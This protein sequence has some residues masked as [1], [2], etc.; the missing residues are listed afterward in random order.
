VT[1]RTL[2]HSFSAG[3]YDRRREATLSLAES[4]GATAVLAF[5]ENRSGIAV[6]Y[7][8]GWPVTRLAQYRLSR[9]ESSL[10]VTFHNHVP[11]ARRVA[12]GA[13]V[14]DADECT[15]DALVAG[16]SSLA[17]LGTVP[18][19]VRARADVAGTRLVPIDA[20]H[21][22]LRMVKSVE[23]QLALRLGAEASD[24]GA[25]ALIDACTPGATDWDLLAS[26]RDAYTR[27]GARDHICYISVTNMSSPDRD[28]PGQVLEGRVLRVGSVVTF[29]LSAA[30]AAEYPGQILRTVTLGPPTDEYRRLHDVAMTARDDVRGQIRAGVPARVLVSASTCVEDG[31]YTSTDDLFH[32]LG[33]GYLEPIGSTAS[34]RPISVPDI[35]LEAGMS[36]V[37]QP[38]VTRSDHLAG[39]QTGEMVLVT[40]DGFED[41]HRIPAGLVTV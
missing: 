31:G 38:N 23:E 1:G 24:A 5:G 30:V 10:W 39:V 35:D 36:L 16:H 20:P 9:S 2:T 12:L 41:I 27:L 15:V 29:E 11:S 8:T 26:A 4:L 28:V 37:V 33:M 17:T 25:R 34:R 13:D 7:L 21:S 19:E 6:T 18:L 14:H 40:D 32:G 22:R 3:E